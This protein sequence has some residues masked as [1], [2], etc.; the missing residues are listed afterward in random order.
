MWFGNKNEVMPK[1]EACETVPDAANA[2]NL[3]HSLAKGFRVLE[4]FTAAEPELL[5]SEVGRRAGLD[6]A[7]AF[8]M[9]NTL[10]ALGYVA[11]VP[12]TRRFCLTLKPL[13]LGFNAIAHTSLRD[14]ARP[15][16]R[17]LVG[18]VNE[19]ASLGVLD[20]ADIV[21]IERAQAGLIRMGVDIR[22]GSRIPATAS[23]I[24]QALLAFL[25]EAEL[26]AVLASSCFERL[27][28][29]VPGSPGELQARL[30]RVRREGTALSDW[31][32][33]NG[34]RVLAAPVLD[35]NGLAMAALSVAA[36]AMR[37]SAE[38]FAAAVRA[39]LLARAR[40]LGLAL[41]AAA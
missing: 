31:A 12:G 24:G 30:V 33:I 27:A 29:D 9:L 32:S 14:L 40:D 5:Q 13:E 21:Y 1:A 7:T 16:L 20:G 38:G 28:P 18:E 2:K 23:A 11:K 26:D 36:P 8:R 10:V 37:M 34:L 25:P 6:N 41:A 35:R 15:V 17:S 4:A 3:V 22:I 39:P 19:A